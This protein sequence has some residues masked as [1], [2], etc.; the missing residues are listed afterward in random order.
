MKKLNS[1]FSKKQNQ[2][3]LL[4]NVSLDTLD[5]ESLEHISL[6]RHITILFVVCLMFL[7]T[8]CSSVPSGNY[9]NPVDLLDDQS[10][11]Y[12][13]IP[14]EADEPLIGRMISKYIPQLSQKD[15]NKISDRTSNIYCGINRSRKGTTIQAAIEGNIPT[16]FLPRILTKKNGWDKRTYIN[17]ELDK[18]HTIYTLQGIDVSFPSN[19]IVLVG[20]NIEYMLNRYDYLN[21]I[22]LA[23]LEGGEGVNAPNIVN[24]VNFTHNDSRK[25]VH[26]IIQDYLKGAITEIRFYANQPK[27]FLAVLTGTD[28]DLKL[29]D[30]SGSF[31]TDPKSDKQY[32]LNIFLNFKENKFMKA[33]KALLGLVFGLTGADTTV[34][35]RTQLQVTGIEISKQQLYKI[36]AI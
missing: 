12:L 18:S 22:P 7:I 11:F 29:T 30:V 6:L 4:S 20:R 9:V 34:V 8:A 23:P 19:S 24:D 16:T 31:T 15:I 33:G 17:E 2:K 27:S 35:D 1:V 14:K 5:K 28:L 13:A 21:S 32:L 26:S 10:A 36:L 25:N 3:S